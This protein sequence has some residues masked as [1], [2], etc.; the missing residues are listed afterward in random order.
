[1]F[2]GVVTVVFSMVLHGASSLFAQFW[3]TPT[4]LYPGDKCFVFIGLQ[5]GGVCKFVQIIDLW[6]NSSRQRSCGDSPGNQLL[7][8][9]APVDRG[10]LFTY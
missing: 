4:P 6:L 8:S 5:G 1:M 3:G 7:K 10:F 2:E 9:E